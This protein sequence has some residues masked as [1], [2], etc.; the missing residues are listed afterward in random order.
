MDYPKNSKLP[1]KT[2]NTPPKV[3]RIITGDV[4]LR[5]KG[6]GER[7]KGSFIRSDPDTVVKHVVTTVVVPA[8]Q[9]MLFETG[10]QALQTMLFGVSGNARTVRRGSIVNT[11]SRVNYQGI[12][13]AQPAARSVS[14]PPRSDGGSRSTSS[15]SDILFGNRGEA[16]VVLEQMT[17]VLDKYDRVSVADVF[18]ASGMTPNHIDYKW[19]WTNLSEA[20]VRRVDGGFIID[21]PRPEPI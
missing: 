1:P 7:L 14:T 12:S 19:G 9:D 2:E 17:L 11:T 18:D 3:E 4:S 13:S 15:A 16:Q 5:K 21:L 8:L 20:S 10:T 6:L